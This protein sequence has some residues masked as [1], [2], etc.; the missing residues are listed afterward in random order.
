MDLSTLV[1]LA[2][3]ASAVLFV[4]GLKR[5]QSPATARP[6]NA[7]AASAMLLAILATLV[8]NQ[9]LDW[10]GILIGVVLGG[11]IGAVAARTVKMTAMPEMVG[12]FNAFGGGASAM[13]AAAEYV[14]LQETGALMAAGTGV[15]IALSLLI[16]AVTFSGSVIAFGKLNGMVTGNPVTFPGQK[17]VNA[18]LFVVILAL[19]GMVAGLLAVVGG[20]TPL[21]TFAVFSGLALLL[22]VL[23]VI[24]IGGAD[25]PVVISLLNSYSGL[26]ACATGFV[27]ENNLLI[28]AGSLVGAAGLIL[29][30]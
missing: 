29:T 9:V 27:L 30:S 8:D 7:L 19:G 3:L 26:A 20:L 18:L 13:V 1:E 17:P 23:L 6:G 4:V 16:G 5:M 21:T 22:G 12:L 25:M 11:L 15:T 14:R 28:V 2:Y 10:T 24:P